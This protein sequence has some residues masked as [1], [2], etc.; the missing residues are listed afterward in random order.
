MR[1]ARGESKRPYFD[2][3]KYLVDWA[4]DGRQVKA[5]VAAKV[6]SASR[7]IQA[8]SFYF[9]PGLTWVRRTSRLRMRCLPEGFIFSG[10]AQAAFE[11]NESENV[12]LGFLGLAN[13]T[14]FDALI[15]V[16]V[17]R[18]G[19]AVQFESGM[20]DRAPWPLV[21]ELPP[22]LG[23]LARS[24]WMLHR[25]LDRSNEV[26]HVFEL[27]A[28]LRFHGPAFASAVSAAGDALQASMRAIEQ[29]QIELDELCFH[30]YDVSDGDRQALTTDAAVTLESPIPTNSDDDLAAGDEENSPAAVDLAP[31]GLA[32]SLVSWMVGVAVGRFDV[33]LAIGKRLCTDATGPFAPVPVCPPG[34]LTSESGLPVKVP[35]ADYPVDVSPILVTDPGHSLDITAR[36]REVFE[37]IFGDEADQWWGGVGFALGARDGEVSGWLAKSLFAHHLEIYHVPRSRQAPILWPMGTR[38][39]SYLVWLYAHHASVDSL[40]RMLNDLVVPKLLAE[41]RK[42]T[43]LR[44]E[45]GVDA[46]ASQRKAI[47]AQE[48][49]VTELRELR[50]QLEMLAPLWV[51][52][53]ND[54]IVVVL[55]P[56]WSLFAHNRPWSKE[57]KKHWVKLAQG[58][59]DWTQIAMH[60]WPERV[61]S[62]CANDR[63]LAI[64]HRLEGVF[65]VA[66]PAS[67]DKW[68][69]REVPTTPVDELVAQRHSPAVDAALER[70]VEW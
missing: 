12:R 8:E 51:P 13:S 31:Y 16:S 36:I 18:T 64:A 44:Q 62:K 55:S 10:G 45:A 65:W 70:M 37:V 15:K 11:G 25:D 23:E 28:L 35:P 33:R 39:G 68:N 49:F 61:I 30:L 67:E 42:L 32:A 27:P 14:I 17:G 26:S 54:G 59:Y 46:T 53:L 58:Q 1:Y 47:D 5:Y 21:G 29:N 40:F 66:D 43:Q 48:H 24:T 56:L 50:E 6:G 4:H 63:S 57:L 52:D 38:S 9:R 3:S 60:L 19:D 69:R 2:T 41:E 34:I 7:K 22:A 20:I